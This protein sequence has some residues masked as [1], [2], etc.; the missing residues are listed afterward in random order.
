MCAM[1]QHTESAATEVVPPVTL[2]LDC[3]S[4]NKGYDGGEL[5][6]PCIVNAD[7]NHRRAA[8]V[9]TR[10]PLVT[11]GPKGR[12]SSPS[13]RKANLMGACESES[14]HYGMR[15]WHVDLPESK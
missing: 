9:V 1:R 3:W 13:V 10:C 6:R 15:G 4:D 5:E 12:V 11:F 2:C 14:H 7:K 8:A